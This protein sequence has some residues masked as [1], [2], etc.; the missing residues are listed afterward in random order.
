MLKIFTD[1]LNTMYNV[2]ILISWCYLQL[3]MKVHI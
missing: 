1:K 2:Q 3:V